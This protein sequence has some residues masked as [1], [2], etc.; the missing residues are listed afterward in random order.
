MYCNTIMLTKF[1][2]SLRSFLSKKFCSHDQQKIHKKRK[3]KLYFIYLNERKKS[4]I[5]TRNI[6]I[7][8]YINSTL[9]WE[10]YIF[11]IVGAPTTLQAKSVSIFTELITTNA[12]IYVVRQKH[13]SLLFNKTKIL[14]FIF[15]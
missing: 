4:T 2:S 3:L 6:Y 13:L 10:G 15:S 1:P 5:S 11:K 8:I 7:Y 12:F 14:F 9:D